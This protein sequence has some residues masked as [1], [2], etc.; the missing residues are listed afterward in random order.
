[1][2]KRIF[3]DIGEGVRPDPRLL[4]YLKRN[5]RVAEDPKDAEGVIVMGGDGRMLRAVHQYG[6]GGRRRLFGL[7][8]GHV[9]FLMNEPRIEVVRE[10]YREEV[11]VI[12]V[13]LLQAKL[14]DAEGR[15]VQTAYAFNDFYFERASSP[16]ARIKITIDGRPYLDPLIADGVIVCTP[17]GSTA[18]NAAAGGPIVPIDS[19]CIVVTG[20]CPAIFHHWR[21]ALLSEKTRVTLRAL[22]IENRPV[23][24]LADGRVIDHVV[25]AVIECADKAEARLVFAR[26]Q[27]FRRKVSDLQFSANLGPAFQRR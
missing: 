17:A 13:K 15:A 12:K 24:F 1:V 22:D 19:R 23:R 14:Y 26:S 3:L 5:F 10:L 2:K 8:H 7:N 4:A 6:K 18:Y 9:G 20:I 16:T 27:D 11:E 21:S 25:E